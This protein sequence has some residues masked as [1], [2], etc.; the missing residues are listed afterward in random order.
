VSDRVGVGTWPLRL[1]AG[2]GVLLIA[3]GLAVLV[4][5]S[6][7]VPALIQLRPSLPPMSRNTAAS[8]VLCGA[9]LLLLVFRGPRWLVTA[10]AG[11][12]AA[13][14]LLT[15]AEF[16]TGIDAGIDQILGPAYITIKSSTPGR[17]SPVGAI[18]LALGSVGLLLAP[19]QLSQRAATW[20]GLTG[21]ILVGAGMA[22]VMG[23]ALG[24]SDVF[25]W[26]DYTRVACHSAFGFCLLG[27]GLVALAW[28]DHTDP[29]RSPRWLPISATFAVATGAIGMWQALIAAGQAPFALLPAVALGFGGVM[30]ATIGTMVYLAQ[31]AQTQSV[32]LRR[33][34]EILSTQIAQRT[35]AE[36]RMFM[37]LDAG[38]MG[39][40][41]LDLKTNLIDRSLRHDQI[42]GYAT[43][44][45]E[46]SRDRFLA[47]AIAEDLPLIR[48]AFHNAQATGV[49]SLECRIHWPDASLHWINVQGRIERDGRGEPCTLLGIITDTTARNTLEAELRMARDAA[50]AASLAKNQ[51]LANMSHE[52]RTP[53]N[54]V[55]GMTELILD[56]DLTSDQR[57]SL[58]I[59]K[60]SADALL[61]VIND[62]LDF[63]RME[64]GRAELDLI[65]FN[66]RD[67]IGD[68]ANSVALR[69][70]QKGLEL[71]VDVAATVPAMLNGDP[72]R[73]RQILVNLLGNAIKFTERGEIV[74]RVTSE[75]AAPPGSSPDLPAAGITLHFS[76]T[77]TGIGIPVHRQGSVFEAFTQADGSVTR[78]FGGTG[79]GL[80]IS[81][82]L[83]AL[84]G[85]RVWV[86]SESGRG[87]TFHFT[88]T[89]APASKA[90]PASADLVGLRDLRALVVDDNAT[91]RRLL[92]GMLR[93]WRMMPTLVETVPEAL[94]AM[95]LA[96]AAGT[97]F[98]V[99]LTDVRMPDA[100]GFV[101]A[102][103]VRA[104][105]A[106]AAAAVMML[107]SAGQPGDA[108]RCREL[109]VAAYLTKPI[110]RS[111]L[112]GA[113]VLA[114]RVQNGDS[115][116]PALVTRH[117]LREGRAG[118]RILLVEDNHI[119]HL[120]ERRGHIV[121]VANNGREAL[122]FVERQTGGERFDCVLM[123]VQMPEMDGFECTQAIRLSERRGTARLPIIAMTA[124]AMEGDESRCLAAGM[125]AYV[126]K[127][128]QPEA[129][130]ETVEHYIG[131]TGRP[132]AAAEE[133]QP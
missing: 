104:E 15:F 67:T 13:A 122:Q 126:S 85:G 43:P 98:D 102:E 131:A 42:F 117:T 96:Q 55:I 19:R 80:T 73:L 29:D 9:A 53:M 2:A 113:M 41:E 91:N 44:C 107:T 48:S 123:D 56:T 112:R 93:G 69:A 76:V 3:L 46:W 88:A 25:G 128:I 129:L 54:G 84:M 59:V 31:R 58:R 75:P 23:F 63:S 100:D 111:E 120:L 16:V 57:E 87:S 68:T 10:C 39:I 21:S 32:A 130:F 50:E 24:S 6:M 5:W 28:R 72:G 49:F 7:H 95:R 14:S 83:V 47:A 70:H 62:I 105:P 108:A 71:I 66:P 36:E 35:A 74:L 124:H 97:P 86:D 106:L 101:L 17:M 40:W 18:C 82:Q 114:L 51:F 89:F 109:G 4:G 27:L 45:A 132:L 92:D 37:A 79:L 119:N 125:D 65:D 121:V 133:R 78:N 38:Q 33:T 20:L 34:N 103:A 118:G 115:E 61:T 30:S 116:R 127:P 90:A 8:F 60:S 110:K 77:D 94:A 12:V 26:G 1:A 64:A 52:I 22:A 11:A 99:V 81:S